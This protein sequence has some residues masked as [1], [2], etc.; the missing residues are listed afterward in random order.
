[1]KS[2]ED[3]IDLFELFKAI[4]MGW[5]VDIELFYGDIHCGWFCFH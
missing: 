2:Q 5:Q 4:C 1:M 3:E